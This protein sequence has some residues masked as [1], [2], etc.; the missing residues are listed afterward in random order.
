MDDR[1][2]ISAPNRDAR[3]PSLSGF[4][5]PVLR[6]RIPGNDNAQQHVTIDPHA[7]SEEA[8]DRLVIELAKHLAE[9]EFNR[10]DRDEGSHLRPIQYR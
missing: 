4:A 5:A 9:L 3:S 10:S 1:P 2:P 8:V 7:I 6:Y